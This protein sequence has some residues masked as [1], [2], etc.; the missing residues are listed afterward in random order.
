MSYLCPLLSVL[1][2]ETFFKS[3]RFFKTDKETER[4]ETLNSSAVEQPHADIQMRVPMNEWRVC[5]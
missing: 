1:V 2:N 4:K 5:R 3:I